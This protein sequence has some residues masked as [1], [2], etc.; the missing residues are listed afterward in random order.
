MTLDGEYESSPSQWVR[1]QVEAYEASGGER[2]NTLR[3]TGLAI[4]VVTMKG[5]RS[6]RLRKVPV[7][8][9]EHD[10]AYALIA[11]KGGAPEHPQWYHN[12]R[13]NP[14]VLIQDGPS[15]RPYLVHEAEGDERRIWWERAVSAYP[16]YE[17]YQQKTDRQIPV[18]VAQPRSV[19]S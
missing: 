16:A 18:L 3:D 4:V 7:M 8:R 17:E 15:P 9:V 11:S 5:S 14:E 12:L 10:G 13:A 6:G 1:E 19:I 2:A